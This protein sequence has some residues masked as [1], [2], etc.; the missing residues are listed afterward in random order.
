M[1]DQNCGCGSEGCGCEPADFYDVMESKMME[2]A[3]A[4]HKT[5]LFEKIKERI[6]KLDGE[7]LDA[8][9]DLVVEAS[10]TKWKTEQ[11]AAKKRA[12]L[13]EKLK[14]IFQE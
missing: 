12:E 11:E 5:V 3:F 9:A 6:E 8:L 7:K 1:Q 10:R 13:R 4:A 14:D 2:M